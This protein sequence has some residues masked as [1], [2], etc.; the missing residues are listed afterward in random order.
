M[1]NAECRRFSDSS[2]PKS[3]QTR[4]QTPT[5]SERQQTHLSRS[6]APDWL[7]PSRYP[8]TLSGIEAH[9]LQVFL[10]KNSTFYLK[11]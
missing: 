3:L 2:Q 8:T 10:V 5:P 9:F 4:P 11:F 7:K 6:V 1:T